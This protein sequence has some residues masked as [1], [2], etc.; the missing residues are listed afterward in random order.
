MVEVEQ[1]EKGQV[2]EWQGLVVARERKRKQ[3]QGVGQALRQKIEWEGCQ[4]PAG[5]ESREARG[6]ACEG[7][8]CERINWSRR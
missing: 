1:G 8:A 7:G 5:R 2:E 3:E 6:H 4:V